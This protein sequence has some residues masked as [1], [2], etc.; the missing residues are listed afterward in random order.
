MLY[1]GLGDGGSGGDPQDRAQDLTELL[2]KM[3]RLDPREDQFPLDPDRNYA[4]PA[5]NPFVASV[6]PGGEN[7]SSGGANGASGEA[8]EAGDG[9]ARPE[10]WA[11]GLRNPWRFSFDSRGRLWIGDVGQNR[12]EVIQLQQE[13]S[14]GGENYGWDKLEGWHD[15]LPRDRKHQEPD[16]P[17]LTIEEIRSRGFEPV[18]WEYRQWHPLIEARR[19]GSITGG[20]FYEGSA[21]PALK[22]RYIF[23]DFMFGK[24]WTLKVKDGRA[25]DVTEITAAIAPAF[26]DGNMDLAISS[27]GEGN[28]GE[29]YIL[30]HKGGRVLKIVE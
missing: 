29:L 14:R 15:Y 24:V 2:G 26:P 30:D 11:Y 18:L 23:A 27:F 19:V 21:V 6:A 5:D 13:N 20:F 17:R 7:D 4:I 1:I 10:I 8:S 25:D 9:G 28:D 12:F 3:L 22:D 16:P